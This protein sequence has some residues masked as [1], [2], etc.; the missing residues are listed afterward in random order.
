MPRPRPAGPADPSYTG[1]IL[2]LTYPMIGNYGVPSEKDV[3]EH[4]LP[5]YF[6][7]GFSIWLRGATAAAAAM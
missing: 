2:T 3:D 5:T 6:E 7:V 1:Q 4:G